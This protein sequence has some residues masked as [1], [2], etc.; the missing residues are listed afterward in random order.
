MNL[1]KREVKATISDVSN[2]YEKSRH[3]ANMVSTVQQVTSLRKKCLPK[4]NL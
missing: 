3:T 2:V 1:K 4:R